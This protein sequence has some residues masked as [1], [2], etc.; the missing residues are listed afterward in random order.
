M[1]P[2]VPESCAR[3]LAL[4]PGLTS[5]SLRELTSNIDAGDRGHEAGGVRSAHGMALPSRAWGVEQHGTFRVTFLAC[6]R[7]KAVLNRHRFY[8]SALGVS[9]LPG[10]QPTSVSLRNWIQCFDTYTNVPQRVI[11]GQMKARPRIEWGGAVSELNGSEN[12]VNKGPVIF[13]CKSKAEKTGGEKQVLFSFFLC[14][15]P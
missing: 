7:S 11:S 4:L 12:F 14:G 6:C 13:K 8:S 9:T 3:H 15:K 10:K 5:V 2:L 1:Q